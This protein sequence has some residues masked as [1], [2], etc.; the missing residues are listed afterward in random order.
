MTKTDLV[1]VKGVKVEND[2]DIGQVQFR[3]RADQLGFAQLYH[4][5]A[6]DTEISDGEYRTY[7]LLLKYAQQD[8]NTYVG[9]ERLAEDRGKH[10][11]TISRHLTE[12]AKRGLISRQRRVGT[13]SLTWIEDVNEVYKNSPVLTKMLNQYSKN[14]KS[15][16]TNSL[17]KEESVK[18]EAGEKE[19]DFLEQTKKSDREHI[20]DVLY[21][22]LRDGTPPPA[23]KQQQV[24]EDAVDT[25][26]L[27]FREINNKP[28]LDH[29]LTS[30]IIAAIRRAYEEKGNAYPFKGNRSP[31]TPIIDC[32]VDAGIE[33]KDQ[34]A[35]STS[36]AEDTAL[37]Q[38][39]WA[40]RPRPEERDPWWE[41]K[42]REMSGQITKA[43]F[44][45]W[46]K[47]TRLLSR[48][49][50]R[51]VVGVPNEYAQDWLSSRLRTV[52]ERTVAEDGITKVVFEVMQESR[53]D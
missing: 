41:Q 17:N 30:K 3:R 21:D 16:L 12:L 40:K 6:L 1:K 4:I 51:I 2:D 50:G 20:Q 46:L 29:D 34:A 24:F 10:F 37:S 15:I 33:V 26:V 36:W 38:Q 5:I 23:P 31:N 9:L 19:G 18:E 49:D 27:E 42:L 47:N 45:A 32:I 35:A 53:N 25:L 22:I 39:T 43:T 8:P 7:A 48:E 14:A 11:V 13:S 44:D 28:R 52:V